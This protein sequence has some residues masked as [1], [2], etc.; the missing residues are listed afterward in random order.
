MQIGLR[1]RG[2]GRGALRLAR[3]VGRAGR[4]LRPPWPRFLVRARRRRLE[5]EELVQREAAKSAFLRLAAHELRGPLALTRGYL[6]MIRAEDLGP[7]PPAA[8]EAL[9][10][11]E[12]KLADMDELVAEMTELARVQHGR[13][14]LQMEELDLFEVAQEAAERVRPLLGARHHLV[15]ERPE[16][17]MRAAGDRLRLRTVL[18]NLLGN[19]IKY[20]PQGGEIRCRVVR[21]DGIL[22]VSVSDPGIGLDPRQLGLLFEPFSRLPGAGAVQAPGLGLG[23]HVAAEI[24]RA[25]GGS[26]EVA[27]GVGG[28]SVFTLSLPALA[29]VVDRGRP[30]A[31][32][33]SRASAMPAFRPARRAGATL[34]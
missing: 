2:L 29:E 15:V 6:D 18:V 23:L 32:S 21:S 11:I 1:V 9:A 17:A 22:H 8:G 31:S 13:A 16:P 28:G 30:A 4:R 19:A 12:A 24:A 7:I 34:P 10:Q 20:S 33:R 3:P 26:L 25:H 14:R 27:P 5:H